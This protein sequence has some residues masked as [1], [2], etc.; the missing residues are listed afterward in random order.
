MLI[1][2]AFI[3]DPAWAQ[4]G[5]GRLVQCWVDDHGQRACGD[6]LPPRFASRE[7]AVLDP[8]GVVKKILPAEKS[9]E[10]R[11]AEQRAHDETL[12][13]TAYDRYLTQN[14]RSAGDLEK[15][16]D[17]RL[18]A[19]DVRLHAAEKALADC[20]A[21][22]DDLRARSNAPSDAGDEAALQLQNQIRNFDS[23][24]AE[25]VGAIAKIKEERERVA[26]QFMHDIERYMS[27]RTAGG[28]AAPL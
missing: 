24:R 27:L 14:F 21:T 26:A 7:R 13:Q 23:A 4:A 10:A 28:P 2:P 22:L 5:G 15:A 3:V 8:H 1:G 17:D 19:L 12:R 9:A 20:S 16:R 18:A 11:E 6:T 25:T